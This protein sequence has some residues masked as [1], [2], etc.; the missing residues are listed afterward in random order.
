MF[1]YKG[2]RKALSGEMSRDLYEAMKKE[3][4]PGSRNSWCEGPEMEV[5]CV[6]KQ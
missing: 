5:S 4:I 3:R 2:A 6:L 1:L